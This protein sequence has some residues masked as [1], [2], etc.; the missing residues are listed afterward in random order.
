MS[1]IN[2]CLQDID[3]PLIAST[4]NNIINR[5]FIL[6]K[7]K[8]IINIFLD[9]DATTLNHLVC[10][11]K[12]TLLVYKI[13][14]HGFGGQHRSELLGILA[15]ELLHALKL[16]SGVIVLAALQILIR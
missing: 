4:I 2:Q 16:Y 13:K 7:E 14:D 8:E 1:K 10:H 11:F 12:L 5:R 9:C 3:R 6:K 15:A